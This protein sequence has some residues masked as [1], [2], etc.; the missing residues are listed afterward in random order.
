MTLRLVLVCL[1]LA[2]LLRAAAA[3][4]PGEL[5]AL[6]SDAGKVTVSG[7]SAGAFMA[8]QLQVAYSG[9][10]VGAGVIAGGPYY[11]AAGNEY[12]TGICVGR[13]PYF[14]PDPALMLRFARDFARAGRIDPLTNLRTRRVYVYSGTEDTVV[15]PVAVATTADF[16][17]QAGVRGDRLKFVRTLPSGHAI[18]T[19]AAGN[20]CGA[21]AP[22]YIN[23]CPLGAGG[24]DQ[25]GEL[26]THLLGP[27]RPPA[28]APQG[29]VLGFDQ[30]AYASRDAGLADTGYLYL[31]DACRAPGAR[32]GVHVALHG[33]Q[34]SVQSVGLRFVEEAGYNRWADRNGLLLLYPQ[35]DP[36]S[37][38]SN[39]YGCWDWWGY[40]GGDYAKK[41]AP[42]MRAI[43]AM[44]D[45]LQ[46]RP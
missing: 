15:R 36:T 27:L 42:Q 5:P 16:F 41:S 9:R 25:A 33:C 11:C 31:P 4:A 26:L 45:R 20:E 38:P 21:N 44:V 28:T 13:V 43:M 2:A 17:R 40:S 37:V 14:A 12:F 6:A 22:P 32:C 29:R 3:A 8:V 39:P 10:I 1:G 35:I 19:P 23:R 24:Y 30:R 34:Q 7:L 46:Q 18:I